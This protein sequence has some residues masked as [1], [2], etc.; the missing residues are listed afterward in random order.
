MRSLDPDLAA[1]LTGSYEIR[2]YADAWYDGATT[3][4]DLPLVDA[5]IEWDAD[6]DVQASLKAV[7]K[8]PDGRLVPREATDPLA[9][10]GQEIA[11]SATVVARGRP[12][13]EPVPLGWFGLQDPESTE[14]WRRRPSGTWRPP[15]ASISVVGEDRMRLL[16]D[17][18]FLAPSQPP[19]GATVVSEI[20]RLVEDLVPVADLDN[21]L[22]DRAVPAGTIYEGDRVP[23]LQALARAIGGNLVVNS[24]GVL[25][26]ARPTQ[27]GDAPV[28]TFTVGEG[29]DILDYRWK[30]TRDGVYNA[31]VASGEAD[32]DKA[33]VRAI[34]Y[35]TSPTDPTR[36]DGPFGRKPYF[37]SSPLLTTTA[38]CVLAAQS[39]LDNLIR[40]RER[41]LTLT[42]RR[43]FLYEPDDPVLVQLPDR[44]L[45]GRLVKIRM[46]LA[47]GRA[48]VTVRALDSRLTLVE[49]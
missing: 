48:T 9:P 27:Y 24:S 41:E 45:L 30:P 25:V 32:G 3:V 26:P 22:V 46:P 36:W 1:V 34:A 8:D 28:W 43:N 7:V 44:E 17:Y 15:T 39:R 16:A 20:N 4:E 14:R 31:V 23:A 35:N 18:P 42:V 10:F 47:P 33:P 21:G 37:F 19:A 2:V 29:G 12:A 40:G 38:Q 6:A 11:V 13:F 5:A 49:S